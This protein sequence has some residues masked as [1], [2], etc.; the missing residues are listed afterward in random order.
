MIRV[1]DRDRR[2]V[3]TLDRPDKRNA[4]TADML[5]A[6]RDAVVAAGQDDGVHAVILTG[7][8]TVF[9]AGADLD[10]ARSGLATSPVWESLSHAVAD[11]PVPTVAALNGTAAGGSLGMVLACDLRIATAETTIFYPVMALG[12]RPQPSD[13]VRLTRLADPGLAARLFLAGERIVASDLKGLIDRIDADTLGA[14]FEMTDA[15]AR[16]D[17]QHVIDLK[18][19]L[20]C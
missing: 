18:A 1:A 12:F 7:A 13:P 16:A 6:L 11:C 2:R 20:R 19:A 14:A 4:L 9:S 17:R 15:A 8:G 3:L 10:A 5:S